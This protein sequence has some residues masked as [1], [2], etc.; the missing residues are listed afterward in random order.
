MGAPVG[1]H[2]NRA[3]VVYW[4]ARTLSFAGTGITV[5]VLPVLVYRLTG[6]PAAVAALSAIEAVPYLVFGLLAGAMADRLNRK[7]MMVACDAAA[8]LLLAGVPAAAA[9]HQLALAQLF[10]TALGIG[11]AFVWFDAANF[12]SL[13]LQRRRARRTRDRTILPRQ[14]RR[15]LRLS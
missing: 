10:L 11:T 9:L 1:L 13:A 3:F 14:S 2:R 15:P 6:S 7:K 4:S 5:V 12:G 8:A